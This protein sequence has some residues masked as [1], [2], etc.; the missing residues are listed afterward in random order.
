[1][2]LTSGTLVGSYEIVAPLGAGGMGEVYRA[3]DPRLGREVALKILPQSVAGN[4]DR[5]RRFEQEARAAGVLNHPNLLT[6]FELGTHGGAPFIVSEYIDGWTLREVLNGQS[7][8]GSSSS[9]VVPKGALSAKRATEYAVNLAQGLAAAHDKLIVH[10]D[11]K[12]ENVLV[13][14]DSRVKLFD[15]GLAKLLDERPFTDEN[16]IQQA[17]HPGVILGTVAYMSP[18]QVRGEAVDHRADIFALGAVLYE[19]LTGTNA[20]R[21][22]SQVETMNA[23]LKDD[24]KPMASIAPALERIVKHALEKNPAHRFQSMRDLAFALETLSGSGEV[25]SADGKK[26]TALK[27]VVA[28]KSNAIFHRLTF[29]RGFLMNAR[30]AR[31]GSIIYGAAWDD[32]PIEIYST[33]AGTRHSRSVGLPGADILSISTTG[34]MAVSLGRRYVHGWVSSGTLARIPL[35]GGAPREV[36]ENVQEAEW[37]PDGKSF[38]ILRRVDESYRIEY[39]IGHVIY[40]TVNWVSHPRFSPKGDLIAFFDHPLFGDDRGSL[41]VI[42]LQGKERFRSESFPSTGGLA[43]SAKG[44][45]VLIARERAETGRDI[46][47]FTL[48]GKERTLLAAPGRYSLFDVSSDGVVLLSFDYCR[49]EIMSGK[50]GNPHDLNLSWF[51]WSFLTSLTPDGSKIVFEEQGAFSRADGEYQIYV[52]S[53]DGSPSVSIGEGYGRAISAD[54]K[55]VAAKTGT[56]AHLQLL[57]TGAGDPRSI[58]LRGLESYYNWEFGPDIDRLFLVG[59][60]PDHGSRIY[61]LDTRG[62]GT[63]RPISPEGTSAPIAVSPDGLRVVANGPDHRLWVYFT[64]GSEPRVIDGALLGERVLSWC[65]DGNGVFVAAQ[66]RTTLPIFRVDLNTGDRTLH[67]TIR[68]VDPGGVMDLSPARITP[69]GQIYAYGYRRYLSDLFVVTGLR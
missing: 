32:Q 19:M 17:T 56:P 35:F 62:D 5:L 28:E 33:V 53:L 1:M 43:W 26:K 67:H 46:V 9:D 69:D 41:V 24:P 57:P 59:N 2:Q 52:R 37:G 30:F 16:T 51:D 54:G 61:L 45:E 68:A 58:P 47:S 31:D 7:S 64:D 22:D 66:G 34:E 8:L 55:W 12:P 39:P 42:D 36:C 20:F 44:D 18:E 65:Q 29:R 10:R 13:T 48:G 3:H 14:T 21:R 49:R 23:I 25:V 60:E 38:L 4:P 63:P 6:V 11:L 15:F 50:V 40:S 27:K